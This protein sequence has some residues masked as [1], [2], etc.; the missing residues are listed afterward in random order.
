MIPRLLMPKIQ[1]TAKSMPVIGILGP[2]QSGKTTLSQAAFPN[3][4]YVSLED[5]KTFRFLTEDPENFFRVHSNDHGIIFDEAQRYPELF[6]YIQVIS[7]AKKHNGYFVLTGSQNF[8]LLE[9]I[10]QSLAGRIA[11]FTLLPLSTEELTLGKLLPHDIDDLLFKGSYPR[12][13][14]Q[15]VVPREWAAD[16]ITTYLERDVRSIRNIENLT[17]FSK[18]I[19]LCAGRIGQLVDLTSLSN[20]CGV[21]VTT[22]KSWLSLL[23]TSYIIFTLQPHYKNFSK[24][25][26]KTPKLYFYDTGLACALLE[27]DSPKHLATHYLR[28]GIFESFVLS[29]IMKKFYNQ[30]RNPS[31]YFWRDKLGLEL[32]GLIDRGGDLFPLEI[33]AGHTIGDNFFT[34]LLAWN[35]ISN[36]LPEINSIIYAG[37]DSQPRSKGYI[38]SWRNLE[39]FFTKIGL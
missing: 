19:G 27:I 18:F 33:K 30:K 35:K 29:E 38:Y 17:L 15:G 13:Y 5:P 12:V 8:L 20:D 2:R 26:V 23:E 3:H 37:D 21:S 36:T 28:G 9:K 31:L 24:R 22:V 32:D 7:D 11:L 14:Q 16:Y 6:S 25:L 1:E 34:N 39:G 10:T 4:V